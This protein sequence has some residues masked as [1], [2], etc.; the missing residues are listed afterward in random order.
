MEPKLVQGGQDWEGKG[1][2]FYVRGVTD[3]PGA[4]LSAQL[5]ES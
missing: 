5:A 4:G 3:E 1:H 2:L